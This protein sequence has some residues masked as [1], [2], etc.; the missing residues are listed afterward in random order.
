MEP[1]IDRRVGKKPGFAVEAAILEHDRCVQIHVR[2]SRK[3]DPMLL[4][5]G[6]ILLRVELDLHD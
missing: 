4:T 6:P 3:R 2:R 5:I 1:P